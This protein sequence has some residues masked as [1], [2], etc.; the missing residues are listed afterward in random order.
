MDSDKY[1]P[2]FL[3][4]D[5]SK[6][7]ATRQILSFLSVDEE[8]SHKRGPSKALFS[9][10]KIPAAAIGD[11]APFFKWQSRPIYDVDG[12]LLFW[13]QSI[14]LDGK[15][16]LTVRTAGSDLLRT[17]VWSVRAGETPE[18]KT[19]I[20][21]ALT[22]L[23]DTPL[24]P[25]MFE[26]ES[27]PRL[28][29]YAYPR[30]GILA[31]SLAQPE[32]R[33]I[34]DLSDRTIV[35][36]EKTEEDAKKQPREESVKTIWSP[37]DLVSR[38]TVERFRGR[39]NRQRGELPG[40]PATRERI[41]TEAAAARDKIE[42]KVTNPALIKKGQ[43]K[44]Y[45]CAPAAMQIILRRYDVIKTQLVIACEMRTD[46]DGTEPVNQADAVDNLAGLFVGLLD[47]TTS[48]TEAREELLLDRP[49][50]VG[51]LAHARA[52]GGFMIEK[53]DRKWLHI[54]DPW[55]QLKGDVYFE[56]WDS[57]YL[58]DFIYVRPA[59]PPPPPP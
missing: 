46:E 28:I 55:P 58:V 13:D 48:F 2:N 49:F 7:I 44:S 16:S 3:T 43:V 38:A 54:Y 14:E 6:E 26:P 36:A 40:M 51:S 9:L 24:K 41:S 45:Y 12:V 21:D 19:L 42:E 59:P 47:N 56:A 20:S 35:P 37:Y 10:S 22:T 34:V 23:A 57:D 17:P 1:K 39:F 31:A 33:Y 25:V 50:K 30:L 4:D 15:N 18:F 53:N 52:C 5:E 27:T 29:C 8:E 32:V 11:R